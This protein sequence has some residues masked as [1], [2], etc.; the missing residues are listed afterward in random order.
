MK[1]YFETHSPE[2][3]RSLGEKIGNRLLP[4]DFVLLF[5]ELGAGKTTLTQGLARGLGVASA[6]Y[7]RSPSF[8][9]VN[10]YHGRLPVVHID[11]YRIE[12]VREMEDLLL[13]EIFPEDGVSI[14][15]WAEKLFPQSTEKPAL[16]IQKWLEIKM[17]ITGEEGRKLG[18]FSKNYPRDSHPVF[19]LH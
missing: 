13:E 18:L 2:E 7:V 4:G 10:Q 16:G 17:E 8:T 19:A 12:S 6:E 9:L 3:T 11:L 5:G 14:I 15:E 1:K